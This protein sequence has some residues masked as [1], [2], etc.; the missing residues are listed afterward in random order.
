MRKASHG[1]SFRQQSERYSRG[2][3]RLADISKR[4]SSQF[5]FNK[6][7]K[8]FLTTEQVEFL[9]EKLEYLEGLV[10]GTEL[11]KSK[12]GE[13]FIEVVKG[14]IKPTTKWEEAFLYVKKRKISLR[15][16]RDELEKR[17]T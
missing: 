4:R 14:R 15:N 1:W 17:N 10:D 12:A 6:E 16:L 2:A 11:P 13:R 8:I 9:V 7:K 3:V 5:V